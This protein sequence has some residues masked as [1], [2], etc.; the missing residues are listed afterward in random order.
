MK[1]SKEDSE[2]SND[3][4]SNNPNPIVY[5]NKKVRMC[6]SSK[7]IQFG[8]NIGQDP[9]NALRRPQQKL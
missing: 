1:R 3:Y 2:D 7:K 6:S 4:Q 9:P 5:H 8:L